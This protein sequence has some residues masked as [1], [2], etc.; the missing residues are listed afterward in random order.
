MKNALEKPEFASLLLGNN[1]DVRGLYRVIRG[2]GT[3]KKNRDM[4]IRAVRIRV[5]RGLPVFCGEWIRL[6]IEDS[7]QFT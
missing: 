5:M 1:R 6:C 2:L 4:R 7:A 3:F